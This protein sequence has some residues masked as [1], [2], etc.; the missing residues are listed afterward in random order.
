MVFVVVFG[1]VGAHAADISGSL[2]SR[3]AG[4][5]SF[6]NSVSC[7]NLGFGPGGGMGA[8]VKVSTGEFKKVDHDGLDFYDCLFER[9]EAAVFRSVSGHHFIDDGFSDGPRKRNA[10]R[11]SF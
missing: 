2:V 1:R 7:S 5:L 9:C 6:R 3:K 11:S 8:N 10:E 4:D